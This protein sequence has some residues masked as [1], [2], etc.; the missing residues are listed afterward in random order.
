MT[1]DPYRILGLPP[2][3]A[4]AEIKR[5]YRV[6]AKANHPDSAGEKALPRFLAIQAAYE[7]LTEPKIRLGGRTRS[8]SRPTEPWRADSGRTR[9]ARGSGRAAGSERGAGSER[10]AGSER[11]AS[12]AGGRARPEGA[13][14]RARPESARGR[15]Q[16]ATGSRGDPASSRASG[17]GTAG[18]TATG[19][20]GAAGAAGAGAAGPRSGSSGRRRAS[21]KATFG[22]TTYDE[23]RDPVDPTWQGASWYGPSSGEY[24]TVNPREYADP[25]KHGPEYQARAAARAARAAEREAEREAAAARDTFA[26][27]DTFARAEAASRA[28]AARRAT[29]IARAEAV[30]LEREAREKARADA[31]SGGFGAP[32]DLTFGFD[33]RRLEA[34]PCR[35]GILALAAWPPLGIAAASLIGEATGCAAFSASCTSLAT[36]YPWIAQIAILAGLLLLPALARILAGGTIAV[37][38]L[39]FPVAAA[40]SASGAGYD[41]VHGPP[42]LI[43]IL[44]IVW[45]GGV[46]LMALRLRRSVPAA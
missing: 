3:A 4:P 18:T 10:D 26:N 5:A 20:A 43:G 6:L 41:R 32:L 7:A 37:V 36:L 46:V 9:E 22:S 11:G 38:A 35:R 27:A 28:A 25:R 39:A 21:R 45:L 42:S 31:D 16:G 24:W 23:V 12:G 30:R 29:A 34:L 44:A 8:A 15:P 14:G 33:F 19:G 17:A 13:G 1:S 40:L 2:G